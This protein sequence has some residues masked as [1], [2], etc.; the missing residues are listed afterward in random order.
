MLKTHQK[1]GG[2]ETTDRQDDVAILMLGEH[3]DRPGGVVAV[4]KL[5]LDHA[6]DAMNITHLPTLIDGS[7]LAKL[8]VFTT[9]L[10]RMIARFLTKRVDLLHIHVSTGG[11]V[12]RQTVTALMALAFKKHVVM[13]CHSGK[14]PSFFDR[15]PKPVRAA[16]AA[17]FRRCHRLIVVSP[18]W[19]GFYAETLCIDPERIVVMQN[20]VALP[21]NPPNRSVTSSVNMLFLGQIN[22]AKG[23]FDL[24]EAVAILAE[25]AKHRFHVTIA[26]HGDLAPA[27]S[28]AD[29]RGITAHVT[30][31][32]WV[33]PEQRDACLA[34]AD[35]FLLPSY[36]EGLPMS[37]LEAM[38]W[39][40]PSIATSVGG[41]P[42]VL[43]DDVE[44]LLVT[45]G[46]VEAL[47]AAMLRMIDDPALRQRLGAA[48]RRRIEPLDVKP[49]IA[50]L[51][52]IYQE[53]TR[54]KHPPLRERT[55]L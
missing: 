25:Q 37:L 9:T 15:Q 27:M 3:L 36:F 16:V 55:T 49:Y 19:E 14:F 26:G 4:Q 35:L 51:Q 2:N 42:D 6:P 5:I 44:G 41:I 28:A 31:P 17:V 45:P 30:F 23:V 21:A 48:A 50:N 47:A 32:G 46:D 24:I 11:S 38:S 52:A 29:E 1:A 34:E 54:R 13:H 8:A 40:L 12:Y 43:D 22:Q 18:H 10:F 53:T 7:A 33:G 20:P 39:G